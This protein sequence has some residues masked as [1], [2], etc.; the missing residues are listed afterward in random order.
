MRSLFH[1]L[2]SL[3]RISST[4]RSLSCRATW[5]IG[6]RFVSGCIHESDQRLVFFPLPITL[7]R[8]LSSKSLPTRMPLKP[9]EIAEP[10]DTF[11]KEVL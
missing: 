7:P 1:S 3:V 11:V 6:L 9:C 2:V 4:M 5:P 10:G 8:C